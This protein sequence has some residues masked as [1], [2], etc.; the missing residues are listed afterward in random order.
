[1]TRIFPIPSHT[2]VQSTLWTR[3]LRLV[4]AAIAAGIVVSAAHASSND[5]LS[6]AKPSVSSTSK[7]TAAHRR[8]YQVGLASWYGAESSGRP[9]ATGEIFDGQQMTCAHRD[10]PLGSWLRVTNLHNHKAIFVR[11]NDRGPL[12]DDRIVDLSQRAAL[13]LDIKGMAYVRL[14][15]T[16]PDEIVRASMPTL[17]ELRQP[18]ILPRTR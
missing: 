7:A 15:L 3:L 5:T 4:P 18:T 6:T 11:V 12:L 9:T 2:P 17:S 13:A 16:T 8:W 1:M 10:L 14:D